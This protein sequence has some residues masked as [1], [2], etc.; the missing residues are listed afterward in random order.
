M[1][2]P[3]GGV[4]HCQSF[5]NVAAYG[6]LRRKTVDAHARFPAH[7]FQK[8]ALPSFKRAIVSHRIQTAVC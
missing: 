3:Y 7:N 2:R 1:E 5:I 8:P 6:K 4:E